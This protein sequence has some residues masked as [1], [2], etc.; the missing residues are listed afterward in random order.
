MPVAVVVDRA[1]AT[2]R[3]GGAELE[4]ATVVEAEQLVGVAVLL[5]VVDQPRIRRRRETPSKAPRRST[6]AR[7]AVQ[8]DASRSRPRA[9]PRTPRSAPACRACS[10][11]GNARRSRPG[12][13]LRLCLWHQY[14]PVCGSRG[15]PRGRSARRGA[16]SARRARARRAARPRARSR[17][18]SSRKA[19]SSAARLRRVPARARTR[20]SRAASSTAR[21]CVR[22]RRAAP[23]RAA[24]RS[25]AAVLTPI[26]RQLNAASSTPVAS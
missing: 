14:S 17:S 18:T 12:R 2:S 1:P 22:T 9:R 7:V 4:L 13:H 3:L 8:H 19:S 10:G 25:Y 23:R 11:A 24:A 5:V 26:S 16:P 15:K 20:S 21:R 6:L